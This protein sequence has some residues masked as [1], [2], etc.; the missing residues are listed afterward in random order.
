MKKIIKVLNMS[1]SINYYMG[2][3][4][5][6]TL[7]V[8]CVRTGYKWRLYSVSIIVRLLLR[9]QCR[10]KLEFSVQLTEILDDYSSRAIC[11]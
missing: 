7:Y 1:Y 11:R 6:D 3:F 2:F 9:F 8:L 10:C 5:L 4:P